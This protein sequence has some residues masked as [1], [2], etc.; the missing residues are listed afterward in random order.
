MNW[1]Q[2]D[3]ACERIL[4]LLSK[5]S[6]DEQKQV[7]EEALWEINQAQLPNQIRTDSPLAFCLDLETTLKMGERT[8]T[9]YDNRTITLQDDPLDLIMRIIP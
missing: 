3:L 5:L 6:E 2:I 8:A 4:Y 7:M 1:E 9:I